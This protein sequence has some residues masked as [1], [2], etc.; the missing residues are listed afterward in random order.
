MDRSQAS[1]PAH[2]SGPWD[3]TE[4]E[5]FAAHYRAAYS[6]MTLVAAGIIGDRAAAEDI[7]QDAAVIAFQ[8]AGEFEP[9]SNFTAWLAE[10]VRRCA[11]NHRRKRLHRRTYPAD[12]ATLATVHG[13]D[14]ASAS[15]QAIGQRGELLPDQGSFDD[16]LLQALNEL[17]PDARCCL[18][19]RTVERL[20]YAEI[21][22]IMN[23]PEGTAMSHVHRSRMA[24]RK[25]LSDEASSAA[26]GPRR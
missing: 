8:R 18:L 17:S 16:E 5:A 6:R 11:L 4:P 19:L 9:G 15:A 14:S 10:I 21:S 24:L 20:S 12:P 23:M 25:A 13:S 2:P 7:V 26:E 3:A 1:R 22:E